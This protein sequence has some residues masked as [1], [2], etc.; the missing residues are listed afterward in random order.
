MKE[1]KP[2]EKLIEKAYH[3]ALTFD[4]LPEDQVVFISE[5]SEGNQYCAKK[6]KGSVNIY[7]MRYAPEKE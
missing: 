3:F 6:S 5:D 7:V 1:E 2:E 4:L